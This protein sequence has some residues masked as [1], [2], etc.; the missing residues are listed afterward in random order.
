MHTSYDKG[1]RIDFDTN[2]T[3][4][5][6]FIYLFIFRKEKEGQQLAYAKFTVHCPKDTSSV[7]NNFLHWIPQIGR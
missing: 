4:T 6:T 5:T 2:Q 1:Y 7:Y 3:D